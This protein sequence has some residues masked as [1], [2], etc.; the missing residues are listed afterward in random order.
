MIVGSCFRE[1]GSIDNYF[2]LKQRECYHQALSLIT[3]YCQDLMQLAYTLTALPSE[4]RK[5]VGS[6]DHR[7]LERCHDILAAVWR[8]RF[9][10]KLRQMELPGFS[11]C[12]NYVCPWRYE[13][14]IHNL[15]ALLRAM[16]CPEDD[17][18]WLKFK[19]EPNV[20]YYWFEWLHKELQSWN[21]EPHIVR[22]VVRIL[23]NQNQPLGN[24]AERALNSMMIE[25]YDDVPWNESYYEEPI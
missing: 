16:K 8:F 5:R 15:E 24:R 19:E 11:P 3:F 10:R 2:M 7:L 18:I 12:Q 23:E 22:L 17:C 14:E 20:L 4:C 9:E 21:R 25:H 1:D 6:Y 13:R